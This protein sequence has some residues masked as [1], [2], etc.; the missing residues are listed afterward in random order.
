M[1]EKLKAGLLPLFKELLDKNTFSDVCVFCMQWGKKFPKQENAGVLFVG[2]AVNGWV[3]A[4][5]DID[6][7]FGKTTDRIF[8]RGD[9]MEW[10]EN[11]SG[12]NET[13]NTNKSAF[14]RV[15]KKI[16]QHL[17]PKDEWFRYVAWSNLCKIAPSEGGNP[18]DPLYYEQLES[19][20]KILEKEI[21]VLSPKFVVL[22]T[23]GWEKDFL[24]YLN[25][26]NHTSS[27]EKVEWDG[28][29]TKLFKIK[30]VFYIASQHPQAKDETKHF[31]VIATLIDKYELR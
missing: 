19:C 13:Y 29:E 31:D 5:T 16:S 4:E 14:W 26:N 21:E 6:V 22:L 11:L 24:F 18:N 27:I 23:S 3:N 12:P 9:Q 15:I 2:K 8:A 10:V 20:R 7:L 30:D 25:G 17:Y 28:Y 1:K